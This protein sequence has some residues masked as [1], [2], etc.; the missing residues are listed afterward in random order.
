MSLHGSTR[1]AAEE[2]EV[3]EHKV[4]QV[5]DDIESVLRNKGLEPDVIVPYVDMNGPIVDK[6]STDYET[7]QGVKEAISWLDQVSETGVSMLSGWDLSTLDF[8]ASEK[9]GVDMDHVGELGAVAQIDGDT[10]STVDVG[11]EQILDFRR[12]AWLEAASRGMTLQ[13]QGNVSAVTGCMYGEGVR[14]DLYKNPMAESSR[15]DFSMDSLLE[16]LEEREEVSDQT[17]TL[18]GDSMVI[19]LSSDNAVS[20]LSDALTQEYPLV[21]IRWESTGDQNVRITENSLGRSDLS[22]EEYLEMFQDFMDDIAEGTSF[23]TDHNPDFSTDFQRTDIGVS[24][25]HGAKYR[26][27]MITE[28][29]TEYVIVSMGDKSGDILEG[30]QTAFVAQEGMPVEQELEGRDMPYATAD[31]AADYSLG[32]AEVIERYSD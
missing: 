19:D 17:Y 23:E 8:V 21:G 27:D 18:Q 24:K 3:A 30:P 29:G 25:E 2:A 11:M 15:Q 14:S 16:Y 10:Y 31:S 1:K 20:A 22:D 12:D 4:E 13:E 32:L 6:E 26:A 28:D 7:H 9:L 5:A